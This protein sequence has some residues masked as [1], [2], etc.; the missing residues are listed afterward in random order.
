MVRAINK[1][2]AMLTLL[3]ALL[4]RAAIYHLLFYSSD[5]LVALC[6]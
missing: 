4:N 1:A 6:L 3:S 5:R 2:D